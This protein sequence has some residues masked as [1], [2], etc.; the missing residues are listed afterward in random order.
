MPGSSRTTSGTAAPDAGLP[1]PEP[2]LGAA[3]RRA[4]LAIVRAAVRAAVLGSPPTCPIDVPSPLREPAGAFV[5]LHAAGALRGC[6][7]SVLPDGP[8]AELVARLAW[9]AA[10]RDPRFAPVRASE[11]SELRL[12]VSV[13]SPAVPVTVDAI[14]PQRHGVCIRLGAASAALLPQVAIRE[15]WDRR[16]LLG[17]LCEK[18]GLPAGAE[19]D[20]ATLLLAFTVTVV[21]GTLDE[22]G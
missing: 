17:A 20:P 8:L 22:P 15:G 13:L 2:A 9:D 4:L 6:I 1:P 14:D 11:L 12:D 18:A 5:S 16:R 10:T 21:E 7:G 3:E 19:R